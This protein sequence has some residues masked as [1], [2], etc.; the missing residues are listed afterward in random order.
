MK[1]CVR[2]Q[3]HAW[4][5]FVT[6]DYD[7]GDGP[8]LRCQCGMYSRAEWNA[9]LP[10]RQVGRIEELIAAEDA[11]HAGREARL[12]AEAVAREAQLAEAIARERREMERDT[13]REEA[14]W[15]RD[16]AL[17]RKKQER[18]AELRANRPLAA[19][20]RRNLTPADIEAIAVLEYRSAR[21]RLH[22]EASYPSSTLGAEAPWMLTAE[23]WH[24]SEL[25]PIYEYCET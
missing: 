8:L 18:R 21:Q 2:R 3:N 7:Q 12:A 10:L 15:R 20:Q 11:Y 16:D 6:L 17:W 4:N 25:E 5:D 23:G 1:L 24:P 13:A 9:T 19:D 14:E 22:V